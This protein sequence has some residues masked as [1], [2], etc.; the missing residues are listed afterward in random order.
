MLQV[1]F[2]CW[3]EV[4]RLCHG[5]WR[6]AVSRK[7]FVLSLPL[8]GKLYLYGTFTIVVDLVP[9]WLYT[10]KV[11]HIS[12]MA[13]MVAILKIYKKCYLLVLLLDIKLY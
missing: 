2:V 5:A 11:H 8:N 9:Y 12:S 7:Q 10:K 4:K 6:I 13:A 3:T 1:S